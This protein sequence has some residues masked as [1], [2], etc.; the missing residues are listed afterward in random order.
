MKDETK[1]T[2]SE[3]VAYVRSLKAMIHTLQ[4]EIKKLERSALVA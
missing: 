4:S 3:L 1:M 2:K